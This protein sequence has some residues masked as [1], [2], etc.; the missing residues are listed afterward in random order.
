MTQKNAFKILLSLVLCLFIAG[1]VNGA[2]NSQSEIGTVTT[3]ETGENLN[4]AETATES[5]DE[6]GTADDD[7]ESTTE[8]DATTDDDTE[9]ETSDADAEDN[10]SDSTDS[11]GTGS[12][13]I[14]SSSSGSSSGSSSSGSS[15]S[16]SSSGSDSSGSSSSSS[17]SGSSSSDS[18][19]SSSTSSGTITVTLTI[20]CQNAKD[21]GA[22]VP[23]YFVQ[24]ATYVGEEGDTVFDALVSVCNDYGITLTY[25]TK[26]YIQ[27]IGGLMEKDCGGSSGWMYAVNGEVPMTAASKYTLAD[28]D[29]VYWY[30]VTSYSDTMR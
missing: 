22:D 2:Y 19:S 12:S 10:N 24:N 5:D 8:D 13:S 25:Q 11:D 9:D 21:Y 29:E 7:G 20:S 6:D 26:T 30:Y 4:T 14:S 17:S 27:G 1:S 23:S 15:S 3:S 28:G 18:S 16:G